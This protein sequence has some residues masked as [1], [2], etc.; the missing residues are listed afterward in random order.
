MKIFSESRASKRAVVRNVVKADTITCNN[1]KCQTASQISL[2]ADGGQKVYMAARIA[3]IGRGC[4]LTRTVWKR[5]SMCIA[6]QRL[7]LGPSSVWGFTASYWYDDDPV[8]SYTV[9]NNVIAPQ[10]ARPRF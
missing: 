4:A 1:A 9:R 6:V 2:A 5:N 3:V 10:P 8:G 7:C